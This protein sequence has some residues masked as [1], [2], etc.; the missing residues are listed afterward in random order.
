M[1]CPSCGHLNAATSVRCV[2]CGTTL[3]Y[4]AVGPSPAAKR[5]S[6]EM[7]TRLLGGIGAFFGFCVTALLLKFIL[8]GLWLSDQE[9]YTYS[10]GGAVIGAA[11]AKLYA[12][13]K[14][15]GL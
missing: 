2:Q 1:Q 14:S 10:V 13:T 11:I 5:A 12:R 6:K 9:V 7:D 3:I 8:S 4:E 15:G